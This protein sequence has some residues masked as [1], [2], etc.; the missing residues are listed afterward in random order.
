MPS[1]IPPDQHAVRFWKGLRPDGDCLVWT[2]YRAQN[3]YGRCY[4][5]GRAP[6]YTHRVAW[7]LANGQPIPDGMSVLHRCDNPPCCNPSH[8][9]LGTQPDNLADMYAK[10]RYKAPPVH[11]KLT[12]D[13]EIAVMQQRNRGAT[14]LALAAEYGV[15]YN[16]IRR[17]IRIAQGL[18]I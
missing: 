15:H 3:G 14:L 8:L 11:R 5:G 13:Q 6:L 10:G 1:K 9:F 7:E 17:T 12:A 4:M 2:G 16:T 18:P